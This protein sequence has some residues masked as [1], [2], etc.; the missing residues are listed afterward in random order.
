MIKAVS[1]LVKSTLQAKI[2]ISVRCYL[3]H[4]RLEPLPYP[5]KPVYKALFVR[6]YL[7]LSVPKHRKALIRLLLSD[8]LLALEQLRLADR[9]HDFVPGDVRLCRLCGV[10]V[11]TPQHAILLCKADDDLVNTRA[12]ALSVVQKTSLRF[13][14]SL[15]SELNALDTLKALIFQNVCL[16]IIA[17]L[18]YDVL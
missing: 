3:L 9:F 4:N 15:I 10:S 8:P 5:E 2:D 17:K 14:P 6:H 11:E 18:V 1:N 7:H 12:T 16:P 13:N